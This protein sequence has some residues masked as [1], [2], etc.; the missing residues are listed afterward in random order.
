MDP[1]TAS[2][3][4]RLLPS[5]QTKLRAQKWDFSKSHP[6]LYAPSRLGRTKPSGCQVKSQRHALPTRAASCGSGSASSPIIRDGRKRRRRRQPPFGRPGPLW[7]GVA[8]A[9]GDVRRREPN[10]R[11]TPITEKGVQRHFSAGQPPFRRCAAEHALA[12]SASG[13]GDVG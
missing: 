13:R 9:K 12:S 10:R 5:T 1:A 11:S 8:V 6:P 2:N 4:R 3:W 7:S